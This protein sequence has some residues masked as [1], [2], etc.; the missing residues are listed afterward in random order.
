MRDIKRKK[1]GNADFMG[2]WNG[3]NTQG[4][5]LNFTWAFHTGIGLLAR[6]GPARASQR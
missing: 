1:G 4:F 3:K 6:A 2:F 5:K